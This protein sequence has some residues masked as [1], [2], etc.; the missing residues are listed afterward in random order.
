V[1][2]ALVRPTVVAPAREAAA[3]HP[4][5]ADRTSPRAFAT[6]GDVTAHQLGLLLEAA[7]WA[8]SASNTQPVRFL[9]GRRGDDAFA[10]LLAALMPANQAWARDA[11]ALVLVAAQTV[12]TDGNPRRWAVYDAGQAAAHLTVQAA[13]LGL[14]VRQMGGFVAADLPAL[15]ADV[16][17]LAVMAVGV[18]RSPEDIPADHPARRLPAR[19]RRPLDELLLDVA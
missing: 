18:P 3:L 8:P 5:L 17:P 14:S 19:S 9:V 2:T 13:S 15:P 7:R 4:L 1:T 6:E 12:D 10:A 11:A 16:T